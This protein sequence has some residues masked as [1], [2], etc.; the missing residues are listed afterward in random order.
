MFYLYNMRKRTFLLFSLI[1]GIT[2][3]GYG[4][5]G[6]TIYKDTAFIAAMLDRHNAFRSALQLAPLEWSPALASDA[7]VYA[8][9]LADIDKGEHDPNAT[10]KEGENLW[11]GT[12]NAFSYG[13]M[14]DT[15]GG[16]KKSFREGVFPDCRV[17]RSAVVGHYTQIVWRNTQAVG[18]AL[19]SNAH[20]DY[21]VCRY[22][23]PGNVIGQK[24][25]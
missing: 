19:V 20:N 16:E 24:P 17:N 4:Q 9:H 15:W 3:S 11:W 10:G 22:S 7:L 5:E 21:L 1:I 2:I 25:Y 6:R 13:F 12:T 14:V 18:C 8:R 23:P